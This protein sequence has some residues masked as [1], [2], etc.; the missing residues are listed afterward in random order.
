MPQQPSALLLSEEQQKARWRS[1]TESVRLTAASII[2]EYDNKLAAVVESSRKELLT[3]SLAAYK[4]KMKRTAEEEAKL[5]SLPGETAKVDGLFDGLVAQWEAVVASFTQLDTDS[6]TPY[7]HEL[8]SHLTER[9][10]YWQSENLKESVRLCSEEASKMGRRLLRDSEQWS[11]DER[12]QSVAA[13]N[14]WVDRLQ[15]DKF[16]VG[17]GRADAKVVYQLYKA[18]R[19]VGDSIRQRT[20]TAQTAYAAAALFAVYAVLLAR[21]ALTARHGHATSQSEL[22]GYG[23]GANNG[24]LSPTLLSSS[25]SVPLS[26][27]Q[28]AVLLLSAVLA[29]ALLYAHSLI[30]DSA[31]GMWLHGLWLLSAALLACS[32]VGLWYLIAGHTGRAGKANHE[33]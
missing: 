9:R 27:V 7:S 2:A 1:D 18:R 4:D 20:S 28:R 31:T 26:V 33:H 3:L 25:S 32:V 21:R 23:D 14:R 11:S 29:A 15:D 13:L 12:F 16:C 10:Q 8:Q 17:P 6:V 5:L 22:L 30:P 24:S 19:E